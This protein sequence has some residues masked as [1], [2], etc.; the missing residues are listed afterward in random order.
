[1]GFNIPA[2]GIALVFTHIFQGCESEPFRRL[3]PP[4]RRAKRRLSRGFY[5][6]QAESAMTVCWLFGCCFSPLPAGF[7]LAEGRTGSPLK[8]A[9]VE[10]KTVVG[11]PALGLPALKGPV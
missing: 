9:P 11:E 1:M 6:R 3:Q 7:L 5:P 10:K 8:R 4:S 2:Q